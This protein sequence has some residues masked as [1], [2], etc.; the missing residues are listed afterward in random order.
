MKTIKDLMQLI[1]TELELNE[2]HVIKFNF[3]IDTEN[4]WLTMKEHAE[5]TNWDSGKPVIEKKYERRIFTLERF[6]T[7]EKLQMLYWTVV[8]KG[9]SAQEKTRTEN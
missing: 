5:F 1:N 6:N 8:C 9:R 2:K 3:D 7:P 4:Q